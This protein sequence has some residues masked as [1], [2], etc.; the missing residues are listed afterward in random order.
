MHDREVSDALWWSLVDRMGPRL[1]VDGLRDGLRVLDA[2][3]LDA[4]CCWL[5]SRTAALSTTAHRA[6]AAYAFEIAR[7]PGQERPWSAPELACPVDF[8]ELRAT[9]V[10]H[11]RDAWAALVAEPTLLPG[12][13]PTGLGRQLREAVGEALAATLLEAQPL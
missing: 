3:E 4:F 1:D 5:D 8:D 6:E 11:G 12:G 9:V 2:A 10:A 13:W 7:I